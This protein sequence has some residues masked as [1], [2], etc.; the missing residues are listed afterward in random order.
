M[1]SSLVHYFRSSADRMPAQEAVLSRDRRVT[2]RELWLDACRVSVFLRMRGLRQGQRV[3]LLMENSAE[4]IASY[5]GA[6]SAGGVVVALNVGS[7]ARDIVNWLQ[8]SGAQWLIADGRHPELPAVMSQG[9]NELVSVIVDSDSESIPRNDRVVMW[10]ELAHGD[11]VDQDI[12]VPTGTDDAAAIIYT[13]GTTGR[14]KGVTLSHRNMVSNVKSI[15]QYLNL[16]SRDRCMTVLP[17]YYSYG[18]S[19]MHTHMAAGGSLVLENSLIYPHRVLEKMVA[20]KTTGFS[21][22]PSTYAL[23]LSRTRLADYDLSGLRYM[24]QAGG[25]MPPAHIQRITQELPHVEFFVMYGQTEATA[26]LTY[27]PSARLN[28]KLGSAGISIPGV[29]I[30][31]HD[32]AGNAVASGVRGEV[33]ARGENIMMGYWN[34]PQQSSLVLKDGWLRTGDVGY[35]DRDGYLFLEGRRSDMIKSGAHRINPKEIEE[36]IAEL[37]G[38]A[39]VAVVGVDDEIMGQVIKAVVI[40]RNGTGLDRRR[41]LMHCRTNLAAYKIPKF[42][43][44]A[45]EL[46]KTASGKIKRFLLSGQGIINEERK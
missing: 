45:S 17:F 6:M 31:V 2:Y 22:V 4:Y 28:E 11:R 34:D 7:K 36:V 38:V 35:I 25:S 43:E 13:S 27:L 32:G 18:N 1:T 41:I 20:E 24:T 19:V 12:P 39:E 15:L 26:R 3:A 40:Q 33:W 42:V 8:H 46:P 23:L 29:Q 44:F 10:S 37:E 30:E 16:S 5:Y 14:P 21:G 9:S